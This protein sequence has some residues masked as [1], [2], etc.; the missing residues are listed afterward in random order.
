MRNSDIRDKLNIFTVKHRILIDLL[1]QE[2]TDWRQKK[3]GEQQADPK[4]GKTG[5][6]AEMAG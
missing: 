4:R 1:A 6:S 5:N 2:K 3:Y